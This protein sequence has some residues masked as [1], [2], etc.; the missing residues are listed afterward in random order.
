MV[1]RL[2]IDGE[3]WTVFVAGAPAA[4]PFHH[5]AWASAI[6]GCYGFDAF[7]L[8]LPRP[9]GHGYLGGVPVI[10]VRHPLSRRRRW[11]SLPFT[12]VCEALVAP[13][14]GPAFAAAL[15]ASRAAAGVVQL[16]V[17]GP[18]PGLRGEV[19]ATR[20]QHV[21][22]LDADPDVTARRSSSAAR[23]NARAARAAGLTIRRGEAEG[24]VTG[25]FYRLHVMTR[26]RLGLPPQPRRFFRA[27][28]HDVLARGLGHVTIV[29]AAGAPVA[30]AIFLDWNG[31]VVYKYGASDTAAWKLRPN[32]L[33]FAHEIQTAC[34]GGRHSFHFG[35][36]DL[37]DEGLRRFKASWGAEE[38]PLVTARFGRPGPADSQ[39]PPT[40]L[41][42]LV[43]RS[44]AFVARSLGEALYRFGA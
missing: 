34:I 22:P 38:Q 40:V 20:V 31:V 5:P 9:D 7:A 13:D 28:W 26:R 8:A 16:R 3:E 10:E 2:P 43:R 12:D 15:E 35:R 14:D 18:F 24:A 21:L 29:E 19:S 23:R 42:A 17:V 30:A 39:P 6:A 27:L 36:T 1:E 25:D 4:T 41:R 33:L 11:S 37:A 32:N 44:P